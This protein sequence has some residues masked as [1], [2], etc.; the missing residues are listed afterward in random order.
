[1]LLITVVHRR[2]FG[3]NGSGTAVVDMSPQQGT[4]GVGAL[5]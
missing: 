1:M 2:H 4:G 3:F 5:L